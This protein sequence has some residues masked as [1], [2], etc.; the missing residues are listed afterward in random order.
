MGQ[1]QGL[2]AVRVGYYYTRVNLRGSEEI[3]DA[4]AE[5]ATLGAVLIERKEEKWAM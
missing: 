2:Q 5:A 1:P 4:F 3:E